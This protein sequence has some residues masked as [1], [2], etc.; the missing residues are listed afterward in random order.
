MRLQ[1]PIRVGRAAVVLG[2]TLYAAVLP[3]SP[4]AQTTIRDSAGVRVVQNPSRARA[5]VVF[6]LG[7]TPSYQVGGPEEPT[8]NE[9]T[10]NQGYLRGVRL[11]DNGFVAI[12]V[13][14]VHFF[15]AA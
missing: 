14:R 1:D 4:A 7:A 13:V 9:F 12:D 5:P 15:D 3:S 6:Q 10:P 8:D 2:A 11:S